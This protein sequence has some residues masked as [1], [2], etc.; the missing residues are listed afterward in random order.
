MRYVR[1][2]TKL[3]PLQVLL[4]D[5]Q[6]SLYETALHFWEEALGDNH[7]ARPPKF[8]ALTPERRDDATADVARVLVETYADEYGAVPELPMLAMIA[9]RQARRGWE[10]LERRGRWIIVLSDGAELVSHLDYTSGAQVRA[11]AYVS[12]W[13]G[14]TL[15]IETELRPGNTA[16]SILAAMLSERAAEVVFGNPPR[17]HSPAVYVTALVPPDRHTPAETERMC[18]RHA[19]SIAEK[20]RATFVWADDT[21]ESQPTRAS[22]AAEERG[23]AAVVSAL[24]RV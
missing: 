1:R 14:D 22:L 21:D 20:V 15:R 3:T 19:R 5:Q 17:G 23:A 13:E 4:A 2:M 8:D 9:A 12:R 16:P 24:G 6:A 7:V 11:W 18:Y 10:R